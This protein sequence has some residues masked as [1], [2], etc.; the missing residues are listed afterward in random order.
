MPIVVEVPNRGSIEFADGTSDADIDAI[1]AK[2]FPPTQED[3]YQKVLGYEQ[4]ASDET[5]SKDEYLAYLQ[6]KKTKPLLGERPMATLGEAALETGKM[7]ATLPY[8]AGE[9]ISETAIMP[10]EGVTRGEAIVGTAAEVAAR[11][12]T[13]ARKL[14]GGLQETILSEIDSLAE[15][16]GQTLRSD[17]DKY[18]AFLGLADVKRKLAKAQMGEQPAAQEFLQAYNIPQEALSPAGLEVGGFVAAPENIAFA[19]GGALAGQALRGAARGI[20]FVAGTAQRVGAG[21][22]TAA[23]VPEVQAGRAVTA[24]TGSEAAG[25]AVERA[26]GTGTTGVA[27]AEALGLPVAGNIPIPGAGMAASAIGTAK[28]VGA[29]LETLGEAGAISGGQA[30]S[31]IQ[32]GLLG[33]GERIA[34]QEGASRAARAFGNVVART[35]ADVIVPKTASILVPALG[36]GAAGGLLAGMTGEEGD[37]I[38]A[39]IGSGFAFGGIESGIR[40]AAAKGVFDANRVRATATEDLNTRPNDVQFTYVNPTTK[41]EQTVTLKDR[42]ARAQIYE[43]LD[44]KQLVKALSEIANA[45]NAGVDVVFHKDGDPVPQDLQQVRYKGVALSTDSVKSGRP[46]ILVNVDKAVPE[47]I[48]HEIL[49]ARIT[50][51]MVARIGSQIIEGNI[52]KAQFKSFANKYAQAMLASGAPAK[53]KAIFNQVKSAFDP[54]LQRAQRIDALRYMADEF[55]A[56]YTQEFLAGKD[57]KTVLPGRLPS[58]FE[59]AFNSAKEAVSDKF[60][61]KALQSGFDPIA[62]TFYGPDGKRIKIPWMDDAIKQ[63]IIERKGFEPSE[64]KLDMRKLTPNQQAALVMSRGFEDLY[65]LNPD[66][67]IGRPKTGQELKLQ[68]IDIAQR[69]IKLLDSLPAADRGTVTGLDA[70]GNTVIQGRLSL[71]EADALARSGIFSAS[72]SRYITEI[73]R[74]IQDGSLLFGSYW[75]VYGPKG[76]PGVYGENQKLFLPYGISLN[77]AGG[78][79]VKLVDFGRVQARMD[80]ALQKQAYKNLFR[81]YDQAMATLRDVYLKNLADPNGKPSAEALGGGVEG[82]RKRNF[83]NEVM[84]A[85]PKKGDVM[86][87]EPTVGYT[88]SR[89]GKSVYEDYRIE[90]I[91]N[92]EQTGMKIPWSGDMGEQSSYRRTQLNFQP[93][94]AIGDKSV[95]SD[96][97]AGFR[98]LSSRGKFRLYSPDGDL[99]GIY[100]SAGQAKLKAEKT[101]ATQTR[102]LT[103]NDQLQYPTRDEV[104]QTAEAGNRNRALDR[105][106][107]REEGGQA[108]GQVRQEGD[109]VIAPDSESFTISKADIG[110]FM[111]ASDKVRLEDYADRK[112]IALAADRMGIGEMSVGPTGAKRKLSVLGQGGRGFMN[113]FNGG[114]WAFSDEATASRFL[115][116]LNADADADGNVIVGI[117][118]QSPINHLKNQTGQLAYVE[119]MQAAIDSRTITKRAADSQVAAMSSAIVNSEAQSIKQSARDKFRKINTFS[120]LK[121]AVNQKQL[122]FADMEP[123]LTQMQRKKLPITAKE[124]EAAGISPADIARDI[125]DPELADVPFGSVVALLGVNVKQ[126]PERTGFHY[127]Y[128]WTI[129]GEAIGYLDKFYN[130]SDLSTEKRIRNSRGEVTAQPLQTVMPVMDN[131]INTIKSKEGIPSAP[132]QRFMPSDAEYFSAVEAGDTAKAQEMVKQA[133]KNAEYDT[134]EFWRSVRRDKYGGELES[135]EQS[136]VTNDKKAA[137]QYKHGIKYALQKVYPKLGDTLVIRSAEDLQRILPN[138]DFSGDNYVFES[139]DRDSVREQ[140][141]ELGYD[142][143]KFEDLTPDNT[144]THDAWLLK[145][146]GTIKSANPIT[147]DDAGNIIPLSQ[148]F[149]SSSPDIRYMPAPVPD[150]SIPGAYSM[151]G[152]RILP[153]KTKGKLRVYSPSGSLV[154]VVG[155]VDDAQRM[156]QRKLQ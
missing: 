60:T 118:V 123:L 77:S 71:A 109:V 56:Y 153:G 21:L 86:I 4:G 107:V 130:I 22:G 121:K 137:R 41:A 78:V 18:Q 38:A 2:E 104:G 74:A 154:G 88:A 141:W 20:P 133:A 8:R 39:A 25:Q 6:A 145:D 19:G 11:S 115:K 62:K 105:T 5:P 81:S 12:E 96:A 128:P 45:E 116:R 82:A 47:T 49:H 16:Y 13:G 122:N 84:G 97:N 28:A 24:I 112:I 9:A 134:R 59:A 100:D 119:A 55:A 14:L 34:A 117:T 131:I 7:L 125:A 90:R 146:S 68:D 92:V 43:Q 148:R 70:K 46:T 120:D 95:E 17:D 66:G 75:K 114:G 85:V 15:R 79:L 63:L 54:K 67:S 31:P 80:A 32:R 57:P 101:Y 50:A 51:D 151:S 111:P 113:I 76:K 37:Q 23:R 147:R 73:A 136:Y 143:V 106:Q 89:Q 99:L 36:A 44:D 93:A 33:F 83:F 64:Q 10:P 1:V 110:R 127:S 108:L 91:Q 124:L 156:I 132:S 142:S 94:E 65:I 52:D 27:A 72:T 138:E 53:A 139:L 3:S 152:Y 42:D 155:S 129:H 40:M 149:Q 26:I 35:G 29:G 150:P 140:I 58:F 103:E 48:P 102:L 30:L 135:R 69:A 61:Q 144:M 126:S 98:I 87:N